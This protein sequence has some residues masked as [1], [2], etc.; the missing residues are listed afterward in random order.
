MRWKVENNA[1]G[2][3]TDNWRGTVICEAHYIDFMFPVISIV[4]QELQVMT[5]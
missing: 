3:N 4:I 1:L 2:F 5:K